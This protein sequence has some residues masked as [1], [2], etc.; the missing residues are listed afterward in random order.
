VHRFQLAIEEVRQAEL[1]TLAATGAGI[2]SAS[3]DRQHK[4]SMKIR[5]QEL[6][7]IILEKRTIEISGNSCIPLNTR[8]MQF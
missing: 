7:R 1:I 3:R 6:R 2:A 5:N 8:I 4:T